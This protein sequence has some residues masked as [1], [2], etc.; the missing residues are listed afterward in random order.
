MWNLWWGW[1]FVQFS[2]CPEDSWNVPLYISM[3]HL[4]QSVSFTTAHPTE[5]GVCLVYRGSNPCRGNRSVCYQMHLNVFWPHANSFQWLYQDYVHEVSVILHENLQ[6]GLLLVVLLHQPPDSSC[7]VSRRILAPPSLALQLHADLRA[8]YFAH[9]PDLWH[10]PR[11][12]NF[13]CAWSWRLCGIIPAAAP[14][15]KKPGSRADHSSRP[16]VAVRNAF[17]Y[18]STPLCTF[19]ECTNKKSHFQWFRGVRTK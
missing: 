9:C 16:S 15:T 18:T 4:S 19:M 14:R 2:R 12:A 8:Y 13:T 17:S 7:Y 1:L 11:L 10:N 3:F 6:A 5:G